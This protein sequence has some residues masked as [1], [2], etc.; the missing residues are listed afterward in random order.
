MTGA[1]R[2]VWDR[3]RGGGEHSV[4]VPPMDGAL[5]PNSRLDEAEIVAT[6]EMPDNLCLRGDKVL[7]TSGAAVLQMDRAGSAPSPLASFDS[8]VT[9]LAAHGDALA[10]ALAERARGDHRRPA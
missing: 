4:T 8:A 1:V 3:L 5:N 9:S 7:F 2:R 6:A 10:V